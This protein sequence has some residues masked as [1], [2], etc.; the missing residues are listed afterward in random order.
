MLIERITIEFHADEG[1]TNTPDSYLSSLS[2]ALGESDARQRLTETAVEIGRDASERREF[3][4][5]TF[6]VKVR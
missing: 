1:D 6:A 4:P 2:D 3:D 5:D